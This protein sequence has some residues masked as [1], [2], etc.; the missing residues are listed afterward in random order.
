MR[1]VITVEFRSIEECR[2]E[3]DGGEDGGERVFN[4]KQPGLRGPAD[5][6]G[7]FGR[8]CDAGL[9]VSDEELLTLRHGRRVHRIG[10]GDPEGRADNHPR[11]WWPEGVGEEADQLRPDGVL[12][13]DGSIG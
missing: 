12:G 5:L 10:K 8:M 11:E 13:D 4:L 3:D 1:L 2:H 7:L 9:G 6:L